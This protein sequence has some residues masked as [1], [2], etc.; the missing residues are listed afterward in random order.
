M[1]PLRAQSTLVVEGRAG[2]AL[3]LG[4]S[5][6]GWGDRRAGS[7]A[8]IHFALRR[9]TRS[10]L[11]LGFSQLRTPCDGEGCGVTPVSTQWE[12]GV[13]I[14]LATDGVVPWLRL[15]AIAPS[16]EGVPPGSSSTDQ[17]GLSDRGWG[18]EVGAGV[19]LPVAE[20]IS[21]G[22]GIRVLAARL[23]AGASDPVTLR[24]MVVDVGLTVGF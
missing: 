22:P 19:R 17:P 20:R 16:I 1:A 8:G 24:W 7:A 14:D 23:R 18:G 3:P 13:R 4:D 12:G 2:V 9:G 10:Y 5:P 15:G 11:Y 6:P 21:V